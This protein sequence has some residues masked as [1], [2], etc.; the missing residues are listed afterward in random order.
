[1]EHSK[2]L[3]M[4]HK[5]LGSWTYGG[6]EGELQDI[7]LIVKIKSF[8]TESTEEELSD[9]QRYPNINI[10]WEDDKKAEHYEKNVS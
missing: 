3:A 10:L 7:I 2:R 4:T 5:I 8:P 1:M 9:Q 6:A